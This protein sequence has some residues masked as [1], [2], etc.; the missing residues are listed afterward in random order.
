MSCLKKEIIRLARKEVK[1]AFTKLNKDKIAINRRIT[2]LRA[3]LDLLKKELT[4]NAR[5]LSSKQDISAPVEEDS[6][7]IRIT[8]KGVKALRRK[9]RLSQVAFAKLL[10][11]SSLTVFK[12]EKKAGKID[13]RS[14][15]RAAFLRVRDLDPREAK[16][17][18][19]KVAASG[20]TPE[21][22][23]P[24]LRNKH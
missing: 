18:L 14:K 7:R 17:T 2:S 23:K 22:R 24:A 19:E 11:V 8:S 1:A 13:M 15:A 9:M 3:E 4:Q 10:D 12:W 21:K 6:K 16:V 20:V 5:A